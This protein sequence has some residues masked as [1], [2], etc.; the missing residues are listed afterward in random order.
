MSAQLAFGSACLIAKAANPELSAQE[1]EKL[2]IQG[3]KEVAMHEVGHTL[4]LRHNFKGSKLHRLSDLND[5]EKV[6]DGAIVASVM[7]YSPTN[8]VPKGGKQG[9]Y[10]ASTIG[11]YDYW[12]IEYGYKTLSGGTSGEL[13][14]LQKIA[15]RSGEPALAYATDE[16]TSSSDPDPDSNLFDLGADGLEYAKQ[17]AQIVKETVPTLVERI[18]KEGE[19]YTQVRRALGVLM[20]EYGK[21]MQ[22]AARY[23]G[24][25]ATSRSHKGDKDAKPPV[26]LIDAKQ[27]REALALLEE[28]VFSD[29]PFQFPPELYAHLGTT[30]W[31]HW[32][33]QG[34]TRKD[35]PVHSIVLMWQSQALDHL[36]STNTLERIHDTEIKV[37]ADVDVLTT[38]ELLE[39]LTRSIFSELDT[40]KEG[41]YTNRNPAISSLR[42]SLQREY[43]Q[44]LS[45][46]A[47]GGRNLSLSFLGI[48]ISGTPSDCQTIAY[49][50]LSAL[51]SRMSQLLKS[52]VK[53][54]SY[55]RAHLQESAS[56]IQKVLDASLTLS[57]P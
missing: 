31:M 26:S 24:G 39:R 21:S 4:G 28:C 14:E 19:D 48:A 50:E 8:I 41:E 2:I 18:P 6:K 12:A 57:G 46:I 40:V 44:R 30:R 9:H 56:R 15:A 10:Y 36:L 55:T 38:A 32:G 43:L 5:P 1:Q 49:S 47:M 7:D 29:K 54:D 34:E 33:M 17:R 13:A 35:F 53:L 11:P 22:F 25:L 45:R 16:D 3:L 51:E 23:V 52:N 20:G 42:R 27:Q 37:P